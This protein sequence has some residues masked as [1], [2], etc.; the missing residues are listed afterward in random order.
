MNLKPLT[1]GVY[2]DNSDIY[3]MNLVPGENV[4]GEDLIEE[5]DFEYRK[6]DPK[7]SKIGA[8]LKKTD[9]LPITYEINSL[10]LGAGDGTTVSHLSDIV[11]H[12]KI[13]AVEMARNP[14]RKLLNLSEKRKNIFPIMADAH[15]THKYSD[16]IQKVDFLYQDIS[17]RD[18]TEIFIKNTRFLKNDHYGFLAVKS[19]S[20]DVSKKPEKIYHEVEKKLK[21]AGLKVK[22]KVDISRWQKG[23]A[24]IIVKN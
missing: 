17:Q 16:I 1:D 3:T 7:R 14:Y 11:T 22:D 10:Y 9:F 5:D 2:K 19:R 13:F 15:N 23:H 20:I 8:Y 6:W 4:Y 12:G 18:Q 21:N 24:V